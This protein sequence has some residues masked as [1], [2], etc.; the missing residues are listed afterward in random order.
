MI[1]AILQEA[2]DRNE[3][4]INISQMLINA[5][6]SEAAGREMLREMRQAYEAEEAAFLVQAHANATGKNAEARKAEIE[7]A[8]ATAC[9]PGGELHHAWFNVQCAIKDGGA[10]TTELETAKVA[11]STAKTSAM[12]TAAM[13]HA[14]AAEPVAA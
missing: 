5:H 14:L 9:K 4:L 11:F 2:R 7:L 13:L 8:L 3:A 12:L 10:A 6:E 1:Q